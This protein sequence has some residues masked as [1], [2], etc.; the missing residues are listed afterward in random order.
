MQQQAN[1]SA[2]TKRRTGLMAIAELRVYIYS[3]FQLPVGSEWKTAS[4]C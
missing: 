3:K 4:P 2:D 1:I